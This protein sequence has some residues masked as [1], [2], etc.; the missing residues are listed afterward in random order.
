[1]KT[2]KFLGASGE[3]TGSGYVLTGDNG[4][5]ILIDFGMFQGTDETQTQNFLPLSFNA[6][7]LQAV[8]LTHAHLDHCGRLPLL[9]MLGYTGKIYSTEATKEITHLSL[10]DSAT[11]DKDQ[12]GQFLYSTDDV[13]KTYKSM[14]SAAYGKPFSIGEFTITF[15]DAG[16]ILGSASI[17]IAEGDQTVIFSGDLGNTPQ[18]LVKPTEYISQGTIVVM[19]STYGDS[20]HPKEDAEAILEQEIIAVEKNGGTLLIP[21]FSIERSQE[22]LHILKSLKSSGKIHT[23]LPVFLDSPMAIEVTELFN[24]FPDLYNKEFA[25][26]THPFDFP[27][28]VYTRTVEESK[29]IPNHGPQV[30]IAGSGMMSGGR[31][32]HHLKH[33]ISQPTT[34]L[35]IVGYQ[36]E[37]TL[38]RRI[39]E[40]DKEIRINDEYIPV[41]AAIS[42]IE[43][44]SSHAD[45]PKLLV[46]LK[47][48]QGVKRV[49][50]VHGDERQRK[51]LA[52]TIQ[53]DTGIE[54]VILPTKDQIAEVK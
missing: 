9:G 15:R 19:E 26:E 50:L 29:A 6:K 27:G 17:E 3:V 2:I 32:L 42:K 38:G 23:E 5:Q 44:L 34:R 20:V 33:F 12:N 7:N 39:E 45:Q 53:E 36:A 4:N 47:H 49:F 18:D 16:H 40:G 43:S 1:M 30:I 54:D 14:E 35:L 24:N 51:N 52:H 13:E 48:I 28:L 22:I 46:W 31:I 21:A 25:K 37:E 11:I 10:L 41:H 8:L